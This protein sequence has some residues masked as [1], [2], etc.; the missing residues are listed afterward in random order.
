MDPQHAQKN[1]SSDKIK[2]KIKE[3]IQQYKIKYN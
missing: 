3:K 1:Y 2:K